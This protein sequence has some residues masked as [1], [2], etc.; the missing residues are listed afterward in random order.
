[1]PLQL[2]DVLATL[3]RWGV[4]GYAILPGWCQGEKSCKLSVH[5]ACHRWNPSQQQE[6]KVAYHSL[7][8]HDSQASSEKGML[9]WPGISLHMCTPGMSHECP[10]FMSTSHC[11]VILP[12]EKSVQSME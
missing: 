4:L 8:W 5:Q 12:S 3:S 11:L 9:S 6:L 7:E 1:M 2:L 10:I